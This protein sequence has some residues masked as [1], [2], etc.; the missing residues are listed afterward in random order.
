MP[1]SPALHYWLLDPSIEFL[2]HGSFGATPKEV[3]DFQG[4][5]RAEIEA[6]PVR[7][8]A[9]ELESR[10]DLAREEVARFLGARAE[11]L[12]FVQNA[13]AGV[14]AVLRSL[15]LKAGDELLTTNQEYNACRNALEFACGRSGA[16]M[17]VVD[18]P[19]PTKGEDE[20][21]RIVLERVSSR[22]RLVLIDHIT[23]Q[24]GLIFPLERIAAELKRRNIDLLVDGAHAPGMIPLDLETLGASWYTGNCHKWICAPK[25]A[26]FLWARED[27]RDTIRPI[28]ISHGANSGR[29]DR[30]RFHLEFDWTGTFDPTAWLAVPASIR[31]LGGLLP[32]GWPEL[33]RT[34]RM[35]ALRARDI[36]CDALG[37]AHPAPNS[38]IGA[39]AAVPIPDGSASAAPSLYGDPLQDTLFERYR[40]EVPIV[41]WPA[42]PRR[43]IRISAQ[44]YNDVSQYESLA[45]ALRQSLEQENVAAE[46]S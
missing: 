16:A 40:I 24:T 27:R 29:N 22:T 6:E 38:M 35:L 25:G 31:F 44:I 26:G 41:P 15:D 34:N 12:A 37:I 11:N 19:F 28:A 23:S 20:I 32:G 18:L 1:Y 3:L 42:P 21:E 14:N 43:L 17:I 9:R 10:L 7:F 30:S 13:T 4:A 33:M 39:M 8:L 2:N 36:L 46:S 45:R 5:L